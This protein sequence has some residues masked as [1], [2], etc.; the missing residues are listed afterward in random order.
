MKPKYLLLQEDGYCTGITEPHETVANTFFVSVS[1]F[2]WIFPCR[3]GYS[4][5]AYQDTTYLILAKI[6]AFIWLQILLTLYNR[7]IEA[8]FSAFKE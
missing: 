3:K 1:V 7:K 6:S 4:I 8:F 2:F 5:R